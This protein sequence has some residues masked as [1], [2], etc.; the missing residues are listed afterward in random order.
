MLT[1]FFLP[2]KVLDAS[3]ADDEPAEPYLYP[4]V[5]KHS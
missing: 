3:I 1:G 2:A 5:A 4:I